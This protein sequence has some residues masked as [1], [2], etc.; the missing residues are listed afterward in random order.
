MKLVNLICVLDFGRGTDND[1]ALPQGLMEPNR[2]R[3][4]YGSLAVGERP[5]TLVTGLARVYTQQC[6]LVTVVRDR[7]GIETCWAKIKYG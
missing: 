2:H 6:M 5:A 3:G 4:E 7:T 1:A